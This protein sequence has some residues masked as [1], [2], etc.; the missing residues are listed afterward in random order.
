[1]LSATS[2]QIVLFTGSNGQTDLPAVHRW[3]DLLRRLNEEAHL[4][5]AH[6]VSSRS[7]SSTLLRVEVLGPGVRHG[8]SLGFRQR[9][10]LVISTLRCR[11][12]KLLSRGTIPQSAYVVD[13]NRVPAQK[14][15]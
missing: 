15:R 14:L 13:W 1:M 8:R 12:R 5:R 10:T 11:R 2:Y 7:V 9:R 6:S 4:P 3:R